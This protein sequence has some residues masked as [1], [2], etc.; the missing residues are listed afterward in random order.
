[1]AEDTPPAPSTARDVAAALL[2]RDRAALALG[3]VLVDAGPGWC[4][5]ELEVGPDLVNGFQVC[6][7]GILFGLGDTAAVLAANGEGRA[8]VAT[9]STI[10]LLSTAPLGT[11]LTATCTE[12]YRRGRSAV[13]DTVIT[14]PDA[15][16]VALVRTRTRLLDG[17]AVAGGGGGGGS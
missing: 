9:G 15:T 1:V 10:E 17:P 16:V 13:H 6:H 4:T 5:L 3:T 7:G 14:T 2:A 8:A 12:V 11:V